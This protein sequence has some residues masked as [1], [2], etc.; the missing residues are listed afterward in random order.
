MVRMI[1]RVDLLATRWA[2][3]I[4]FRKLMVLARKAFFKVNN[5]TWIPRGE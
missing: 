2:L 4:S 1:F 3:P 5:W